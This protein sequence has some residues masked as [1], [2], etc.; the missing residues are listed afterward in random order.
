[1]PKHKAIIQRDAARRA[2]W[3]QPLLD[4]LS[5]GASIRAAARQVGVSNQS[6]HRAMA[7]SATVRNEVYRCYTMGTKCLVI[8]SL[9]VKRPQVYRDGAAQMAKHRSI[10]LEL[11]AIETEGGK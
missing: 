7:A 5:L 11:K 9:N 2:A 6:V 8:E 4:A 10:T 3:L 1:M